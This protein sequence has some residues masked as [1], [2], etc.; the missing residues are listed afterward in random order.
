MSSSLRR[1]AL[2]AALALSIAPLAACGA[3]NDAQTH[4][5][6]PD[7]AA[8]AVGDIQVQ[9]VVILTQKAGSGPATVSARIFNNGAADQTLQSL[10]IG[11]TALT[12]NLSGAAGGQNVTVP[13]HGSVLLG[14]T[15]NPAA[16]IPS[17][18]EAFRDGDFQRIVLTF[19]ETGEV[20]LAAS[21]LPAT[22]YYEKYGPSGTPSPTAKPT[23]TA[24]P[25]PAATPQNGGTQTPTG[26]PTG[27]ATATPTASATKK[28]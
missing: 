2:A 14:G 4:Q 3:G 12:A 1:G 19:S 25:T 22:G 5:V 13:A 26:T 27:T 23:G 16:T 15:G 8:T 21:V 24:T 7:S 18:N 6:R 10:K 11:D 20:A 28:S 9:N 17:S